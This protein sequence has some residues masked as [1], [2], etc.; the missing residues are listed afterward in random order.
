MNI[1]EEAYEAAEQ[2]YE[3]LQA[4]IYN[5]AGNHSSGEEKE[6]EDDVSEGVHSND[7]FNDYFKSE[8]MNLAHSD[9]LVV[10][11]KRHAPRMQFHATV[12]GHVM[13]MD[14]TMARACESCGKEFPSRN[15]LFAYLRT[16]KH[17]KKAEMML[18]FNK[19]EVIESDA[20]KEKV[21][22]GYAFR[23][24]HFTEIKYR[25]SLEYP[26]DWG[27]LDSES[28]MSLMEESILSQLP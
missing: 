19:V 3:T 13:H 7:D 15:K 27:C 5:I 2:E 12:M 14:T 1:A 26:E 21:G 11:N 16:R 18:P 4:K 24:H 20:P 28:S 6:D 9:A 23:D 8:D 25:L 10:P 17:Q 22:T